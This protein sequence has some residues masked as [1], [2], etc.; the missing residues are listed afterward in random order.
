MRKQ[1][2]YCKQNTQLWLL[3]FRRLHG[4]EGG[5]SFLILVDGQQ[6][7]D[8]AVNLPHVLLHFYLKR[9]ART[10]Q[11]CFVRTFP[12]PAQH[13]INT[14]NR[15]PSPSTT[16]CSWHIRHLSPSTSVCSWHIRH[17]TPSTTVC[18]WH[19]KQTSFPRLQFSGSCVQATSTRSFPSVEMVHDTQAA[20]QQNICR[21]HST[22]PTN[23]TRPQAIS[24]GW[25]WLCGEETVH[26]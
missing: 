16:V 11:C 13:A 4:D 23:I 17:L 6:S 22:Q 1:S 12:K 5:A 20:W 18:S 21:R 9:V 14:L 24:S 7:L 15:H 25:W 19:I 3:T 10:R 26:S 8:G 2:K